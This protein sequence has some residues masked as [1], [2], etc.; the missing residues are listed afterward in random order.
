[1]N[2]PTGDWGADDIPVRAAAVRAA[3]LDGEAVLYGIEQG[4]SVLLNESAAAVWAAIDG[5]STVREISADL[6]D[7]HGVDRPTV[8]GDVIASLSV[9]ETLRLVSRILVV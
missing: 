3:F 8:I 5:Q 2:A 4:R 7:L 6:A 9:F 1:M